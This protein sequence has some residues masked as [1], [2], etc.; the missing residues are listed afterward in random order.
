MTT[1]P[2]LVIAFN[3]QNR[4]H[5]RHSGRP[6]G[7]PESGSAWHNGESLCAESD[8]GFSFGAPE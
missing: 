5:S 6:M 4:P 1:I 3:L 8:S 2:A 7:D